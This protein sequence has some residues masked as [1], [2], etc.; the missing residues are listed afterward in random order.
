MPIRIA[1]GAPLLRIVA[2]G[3]ISVENLDAHFDEL[4][5]IARTTEG[6]VATL[7]DARGVDLRSLG[8][9]HRDCAV[10]HLRRL[11]PLVQGRYVA[12]A[13]VIDTAWGRALARMLH[14]FVKPA[15]QTKIFGAALPAEAWARE[16]LRLSSSS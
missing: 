6:A 9:A 7:I 2:E 15:Q 1:S 14:L 13:M 10:E 3:A 16:R 12:Q 11:Q 8:G 5:A 4:E